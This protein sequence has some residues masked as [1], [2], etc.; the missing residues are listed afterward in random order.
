M[1][2]VK[3]GFKARRRRNRVL[4][5]TE[6]Y[7]LGRK[8]RFR[9][10]VEVLH[11]AWEYGY[12]SRKLKKRDFRRLWITRINAAARLNGTT[13]SRLVSGLKKA[14]IGLDRKILSEIAIHDPSSFGAVAKLASS[15]AKA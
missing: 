2:R 6:G 10:A 3:R 1:P 15:P 13:Y 4:N 12:I 7:F 8:N 5:Q 14:G 9:Q 11:H